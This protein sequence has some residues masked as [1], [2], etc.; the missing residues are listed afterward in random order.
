MQYIAGLLQFFG[1]AEALTITRLRDL[2]TE[3]ITLAG[4]SFMQITE[5]GAVFV[6]QR[7]LQIAHRQRHS[8]T[9]HHHQAT[10]DT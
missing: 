5:H 4:Q 3:T 8:T 1:N 10:D 2:R 6:F 9:L 7:L